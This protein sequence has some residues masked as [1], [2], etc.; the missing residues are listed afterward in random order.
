MSEASRATPDSVKRMIEELPDN[1]MP[2]IFNFI[3]LECMK[4]NT[5]KGKSL[6]KLVESIEKATGGK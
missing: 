4:R 5:F 1:S 3:V 2:A 6:A